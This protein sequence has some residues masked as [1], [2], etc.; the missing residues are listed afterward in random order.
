MAFQGDIR[1]A[2]IPQGLVRSRAPS[3]PLAP[4][5]ACDPP[6][7]SRHPPGHGAH[8]ELG[9]TS[10]ISVSLSP[11][12]HAGLRS[13]AASGQRSLGWVMRYAL[14]K[15]LERHATQLEFPFDPNSTKPVGAPKDVSRAI[16]HLASVDW[17]RSRRR[18]SGTIHNLHS[19]PTRF[20]PQVPAKLIEMFSA[21]GETVLDPFC[22]S[23]TTLVEAARQGRRAVGI[24]LSPLAIL[25]SRAKSTRLSAEDRKAIRAAAAQAASLVFSFCGHAANYVSGLESL[26][27]LVRAHCSD[28]RIDP[29]TSVP[30]ATTLVELSRWLPPQILVEVILIRTAI[31]QCPLVPAR[32]LLM[33]A[34]SSILLPLSYQKSETRLARVAREITP[35]KGLDLWRQKVVDLEQLLTREQESLPW[36]SAELYEADARNL[37][38]LQPCCVDL[39]VTSPPYPNVYDYRAFQQRRLL[40]LGLRR[41]DRI[42]I[43]IGS[44]QTFRRRN[45]GEFQLI[46]KAEISEVLTA[47]KRVLKPSGICAFVIGPSRIGG[48]EEDNASSL[49]AA[50]A[51]TGLRVL[52]SL[53]TARSSTTASLR[54]NRPSGNTEKIVVL[55]S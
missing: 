31:D 30:D 52:A 7:S 55:Q 20:A 13:L 6:S 27:S 45:R 53:S 40:A 1:S 49:Q 22:G 9:A 43:D 26:D 25:I 15:L 10:R 24:D 21:P 34:L 35:R 51:D 42:S 14:R 38:F 23:G 33:V 32:N 54:Q 29:A 39:V 17:S 28:L 8:L 12:E 16:E 5:L 36:P 2:V 11:Y 46:F 50:A 19:Y 4:E 41:A 18:T 37:D 47:L 3:E 48:E 44:A